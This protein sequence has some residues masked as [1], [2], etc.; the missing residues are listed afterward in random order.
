MR[1]EQKIIWCWLDVCVKVIFD[2]SQCYVNTHVL[3]HTIITLK[4]QNLY[5]CILLNC[6]IFKRN[7]HI[8]IQD[9]IELTPLQYYNLSTFPTYWYI[10]EAS[11]SKDVDALK[12][13][14]VQCD[15]FYEGQIQQDI[16]ELLVMLIEVI[17][18]GSV[19]YC[20]SMMIIPQGFL[21]LISYFHLC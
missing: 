2:N 13:L 8:M 11:N 12:C 4:S 1:R 16:M 6:N 5:I 10:A 3:L 17:N 21:H 19:P 9:I 14:L 20:D 15:T 18:K 7:I